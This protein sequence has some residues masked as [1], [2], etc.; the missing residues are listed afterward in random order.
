MPS[1]SSRGSCEKLSAKTL[2]RSRRAF[3]EE[4]GS[5]R[6]PRAGLSVAEARRRLAFRGSQTVLTAGVRWVLPFL[7]F[8]MPDSS[9]E[10]WYR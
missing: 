7:S 10:D 8:H 3:F 9:S 1:V 5:V 4:D 6:V 2:I